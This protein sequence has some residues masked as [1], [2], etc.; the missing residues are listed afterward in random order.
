MSPIVDRPPLNVPPIPSPAKRPN[1]LVAATLIGD[2]GLPRRMSSRLNPKRSPMTCPL[3]AVRCKGELPMRPFRTGRSM[4]AAVVNGPPGLF[5]TIAG[6]IGQIGNVVA[7][8]C[9]ALNCRK[10]KLTTAQL[11]P[12]AKLS[13]PSQSAPGS[14]AGVPGARPGKAAV[15][16]RDGAQ[17][18][19]SARSRSKADGVKA[20][21]CPPAA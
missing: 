21:R 15:E 13:R 10:L 1:R 6:P 19:R 9:R 18:G 12:K 2:C 3:A 5:D 16:L 17:R 8:S 4:R 11:V 7:P 20:R 14:A